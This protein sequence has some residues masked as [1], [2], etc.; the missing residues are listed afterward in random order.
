[1]NWNSTVGFLS[2]LA[3]FSPVIIILAFKL[4]RYK[5]YIALFIY[6]LLAFS[7]N[8]M[9]EGLIVLP[10]NF[11]RSFSILVNLLD[12]P[13]MLLFIMLFSTS[14][15]QTNRMKMLLLIF[16]C[17]EIVVV[18]VKG[19]I[20]PTVTIVMGPG[21]ALI[22]GYSLYFFVQTI[23]KSFLHVKVV[24]KAI[25]ASAICFAYGCFIFIYLMHYVY[26]LEDVS[27]IFLIYFIVTIIYCTLLSVGLVIES[28]RMRKLEELRVTR[29]E[30]LAFFSDEKK[31]VV[32]KETPGQLNFY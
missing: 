3:L 23:K 19:L 1:M 27:N 30:L 5:N 20:I 31:P 22:F 15:T 11:V 13:L 4:I 17:F 16:I 32:S 18:S 10:K 29:K 21:L 14:K 6:C 2:T 24:G 9:T 26:A 25:M 7:Y 12:I 28:K 8:L